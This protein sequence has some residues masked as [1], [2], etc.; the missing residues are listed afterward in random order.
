MKGQDD[1]ASDGAY[2]GR[3]EDQV[4]QDEEEAGY[5]IESIMVPKSRKEGKSYVMYTCSCLGNS[6][7]REREREERSRQ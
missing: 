3:K 1:I 7:K 6:I 4:K 5:G 2:E